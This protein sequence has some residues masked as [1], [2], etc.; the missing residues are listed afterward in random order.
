MKIACRIDTPLAC[1]LPAA[2]G[3]AQAKVSDHQKVRSGERQPGLQLRE[4]DSRR[5]SRAIGIITD[6]ASCGII[7]DPLVSRR[8]DA[9]GAVGERRECACI[10]PRKNCTIKKEAIASG[11]EVGDGIDVLRAA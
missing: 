4:G 2:R 1:A 5:T 3:G 8:R 7:E 10:E 9:A 6:K 11:S